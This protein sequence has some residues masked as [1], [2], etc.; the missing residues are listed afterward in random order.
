M[1]FRH[2]PWG[3]VDGLDESAVDLFLIPTSHIMDLF[4][5]NVDGLIL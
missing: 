2:V 3:R 5:K 1:A 4:E